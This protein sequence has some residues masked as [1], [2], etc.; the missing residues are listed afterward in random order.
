[1]KHKTGIGVRV[2]GSRLGLIKAARRR[3]SWLDLACAKMATASF[4]LVGERDATMDRLIQR[5]TLQR[6]YMAQQQEMARQTESDKQRT[7]FTSEPPTL[8]S[9]R[10]CN[11]NEFHIDEIRQRLLALGFDPSEIHRKHWEKAAVA[12]L[13]E[14]MGH[15]NEQSKGLGLGVGQENLLYLLSNHCGHIV[16]TDVYA[17]IFSQGTRMSIQDVYDRA[18][19]VYRR[20]RL[21]ILAMDMRNLDFP[22]ATFDFVWSISSVEH[23]ESVEQVL[24]AFREIDRVIKPGGHAF[25]TTEWN[26]VPSNAI[27]Q[28]RAILFDE[29]LCAWIFSKLRTLALATPLHLCQPYHPDHFCAAKWTTASGLDIHPCVNIFSSGTFI[30]PVVLVCKKEAIKERN[31]QDL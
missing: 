10:L 16:G 23:L 18:P 11:V 15:H 7:L 4:L 5:I 28:P 3:S 12:F 30:T 22:D 31:S 21:E 9:S 29:V 14:A 8:R 1:M 17:P 2:F 20:E 13:V 25:I 24:T 26:L 19:F 27:Y 6:A